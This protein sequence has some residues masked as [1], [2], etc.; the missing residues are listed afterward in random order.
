MYRVSTIQSFDDPALAPYRTLKRQ[1]EHRQKGWFVAE[2][3]KVVER[4]V[5]SRLEILS[6]VIPEDGW[7]SFEPLLHS[8]NESFEVFV[9]PKS[10]LEQLTGF[11][12]YQGYMGVAKVPRVLS[13][14]AV[15]QGSKSPRLFVALDGLSGPDN[16]GALVRTAAAFGAD[17]VIVGETCASPFLRRAVRGSMGAVFEVPILES[18]SLPQTL[19]EL[20]RHSVQVVA[21]HPHG[22]EV[23]YRDVCLT[24]DVCLV[25]G[26]EGMGLSPEVLKACDV[27][28]ALPMARGVDS[29]NVGSAGAVFLYEILR[30]R[31]GA[32]KPV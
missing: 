1:Q 11:H 18:P 6:L 31:Q 7:K 19:A 3:D 14:E 23:L 25:L 2:G 22:D 20:R 29:L 27:A 24:G 26:S 9:A 16:V 5:Q 4:L 32:S 17:A 13:I 21:A 8:R 10:V 30:Q 12:L 28:A 15:V